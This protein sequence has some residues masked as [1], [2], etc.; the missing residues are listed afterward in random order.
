[1]LNK[2]GLRRAIALLLVVLGGLVMFFA[3]ETWAGLALLVLGVSLEVA[4]IA[5]RHRDSD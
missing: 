2:P 3:P 4:G 1:M 5:L